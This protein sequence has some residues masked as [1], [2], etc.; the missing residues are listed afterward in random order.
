M[1]A[2]K[3]IINIPLHSSCVTLR[4]LG[5]PNPRSPAKQTTRRRIPAEEVRC[6][7]I[8]AATRAPELIMRHVCGGPAEIATKPLK[9]NKISSLSGLQAP[10]PIPS[11][12]KP[13]SLPPRP[14]PIAYNKSL[15]ASLP[16]SFGDRRTCAITEKK[17]QNPNLQIA[18]DPPRYNVFRSYP[19]WSFMSGK[20]VSTTY[21]SVLRFTFQDS[22]FGR[23]LVC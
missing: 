22:H 12:Q 18:R 11:L 19:F 5:A 20:I 9:T 16:S 7:T 14:A 17:K 4:Q 3:Q 21:F 13:C 6:P 1:G 23:C 2:L 10:A 8:W 15:C